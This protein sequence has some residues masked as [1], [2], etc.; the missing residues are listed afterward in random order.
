[1]PI[2]IKELIIRATVGNGSESKEGSTASD[3]KKPETSTEER[4]VAR[5]MEQVMEYLRMQHER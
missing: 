2:E 1:M 4:I 3:S 5:C